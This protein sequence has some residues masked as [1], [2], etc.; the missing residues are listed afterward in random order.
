MERELPSVSHSLG[1]AP[2]DRDRNGARVRS[3]AAGRE[4]AGDRCRWKPEN[5]LAIFPGKGRKREEVPG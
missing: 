2:S 4:G 1:I 3:C 5:E